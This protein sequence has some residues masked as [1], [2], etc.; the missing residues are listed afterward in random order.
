MR[1]LLFLSLLL[2]SAAHAHEIGTTQVRLFVHRGGAWNASI[3]T[4][5]LSLLNKLEVAAGMPRSGALDAGALRAKL[6]AN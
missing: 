6:A 1:R 3:T 2:A 4:A 5:P